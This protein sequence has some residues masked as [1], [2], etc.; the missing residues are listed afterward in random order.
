MTDRMHGWRQVA[1][2]LA[3]ADNE[4][5]LATL[6]IAVPV[7]RARSWG[8]HVLRDIEDL[9]EIYD[10]DPD[11]GAAAEALEADLAAFVSPEALDALRD[12]AMLFARPIDGDLDDW[13]KAFFV[14]G[15]QDK[16]RWLTPKARLRPDLRELVLSFEAQVDDPDDFVDRSVYEQAEDPWIVAFA[17]THGFWPFEIADSWAALRQTLAAVRALHLTLTPADREEFET[18]SQIVLYPGMRRRN[19]PPAPRLRLAYAAAPGWHINGPE[20]VE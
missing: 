7:E 1:Y 15:S 3:S 8:R 17:Q 14:L 12:G 18:W 9:F 10:I 6:R 5:L 13:S 2:V 11:G 16:Q 20:L 4:R 19:W